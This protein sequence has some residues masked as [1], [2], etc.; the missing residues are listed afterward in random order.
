MLNY[1]DAKDTHDIMSCRRFNGK[2]QAGRGGTRGCPPHSCFH[3]DA[4]KRM[5]ACMKI[6]AAVHDTGFRGDA[7]PQ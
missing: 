7:A 3:T 1:V 5:H 4:H 6:N 2:R